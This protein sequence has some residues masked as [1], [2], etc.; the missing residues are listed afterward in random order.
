MPILLKIFLM[1]A[2][3]SVF[4]FGGGYVMFPMLLDDIE[5]N[6]MLTTRQITDV[7]AIAGMSPGAVAINAAVGT[8]FKVE[9]ALGVIAAF[10]GIAIPCAVIVITVATFFFKVYDHRLV[11]SALYGLRP[12]ITGIIV[13]AAVKIAMGNRII[14]A[15]ADDRINNGLDISIQGQQIFELK[16]LLIAAASFVLLVKTK[17]HP[18]FIILG[19]GAVGILLY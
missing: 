19:A 18:V 17:V 10:L 14:A 11:K 16:S 8:G 12:V 1:F 2:K 9:G 5:K 7:I 4:A 15:A 6:G 3:L 13:F